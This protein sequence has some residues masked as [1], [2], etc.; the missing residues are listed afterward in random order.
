M[1]ERVKGQAVFKLPTGSY[2]Q[3]EK[4]NLRHLPLAGRTRLPSGD[5]RKGWAN[6][7]IF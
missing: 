2:E 3:W 6:W 7:Q 1:E 4:I 5:R